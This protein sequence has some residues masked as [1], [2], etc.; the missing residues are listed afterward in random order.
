VPWLATVLYPLLRYSYK[1]WT[2]RRK[3]P[4]GGPKDVFLD[5]H[6]TVIDCWTW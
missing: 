3:F 5:L 4:Y 2:E 1:G 6:A